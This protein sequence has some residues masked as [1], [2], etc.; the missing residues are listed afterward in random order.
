MIRRPPRSTQSRSS[1][2]SDVYKRQWYGYP[3]ATTYAVTLG[4]ITTVDGDTTSTVTIAT[5]PAA[6][7][8]TVTLTVVPKTGMRLKAGTLVAAYN[9]GT[10]QVATLSGAGPYTF[11][12]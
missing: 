7:G 12:M 9:N 6:A 5:S 4:T 3:T 2:A 10:P 1:A 11:T 8:A